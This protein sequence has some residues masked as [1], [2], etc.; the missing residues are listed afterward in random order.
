MNRFIKLFY[1][2]FNRFR[3]LYLSL[4][5]A[6][7]ILQM[8]GLYWYVQSKVSN[9]NDL[10]AVNSLSE[11]EYIF[12]YGLTHFSGYT[13]NSMWFLAPIVLSIAVLL[14]YV[15]M[16]WYRDWLGKNMFI[17][18]LMMLPT[19]RMNM[20]W[21]KLSVVLMSVLGLVGF[22]L[23]LLP[24]EMKLFQ[25]WFPDT[26]IKTVGIQE[27]MMNNP[28]LNVLYPDTFLEFVVYYTLGASAVVVLFTAILMERSF[29]WKGIVAGLVYTA[30][31][32]LVFFLPVIIAE[33]IGSPYF[34]PIE[35]LLMMIVSWALVTA[36][37]LWLSFY[38][39]KRRVSV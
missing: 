16:I 3:F 37:S 26:F 7:V 11:E 9:I 23:L 34:Y 4:L 1:Y 22:Q 10:M 25:L 21:A 13:L 5:A 27:V 15:F 30:V 2:E 24:I 19:T 14:L 35:M 28:I 29:R 39:I 32:C 38:L 36:G 8:G 31:A 12:K 33:M 17:Y 20:Y 6:T 18:R